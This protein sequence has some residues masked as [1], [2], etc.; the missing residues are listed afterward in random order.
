MAML[1]AASEA[2]RRFDRFPAVSALTIDHGLRAQA[3]EEARFVG[4][5]CRELGVPHRIVRLVTDAPKTGVQAWAREQRLRAFREAALAAPGSIVL[6]AH[7]ADD[8]VETNRM[9]LGRV[10]EGRGFE[11]FGIAPF[12]WLHGTWLYR[13]FI[14][15]PRHALRRFMIQHRLEWVEDPFNADDRFERARIRTWTPDYDALQDPLYE[16]QRTAVVRR[17]ALARAGAKALQTRVRR[18]GD[19]GFEI[20]WTPHTDRKDEALVMAIR[21]VCGHVG[22]H[23]NLPTALKIG[24]VLRRLQTGVRVTGAARCLFR[25]RADVLSI[26]REQRRTASIPARPDL[27]PWPTLVPAHD[28]PVA[29]ALYRVLKKSAIP[30]PPVAL[31]RNIASHV[32]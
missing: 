32:V 3:A 15:L 13:P 7:T 28:V 9:R 20:D 30:Q 6:A 1:H 25:L 2:K 26:E 5:V 12:A 10:G 23:V 31:N 18:L 8:S 22:S 11:A 29:D 16:E 19:L 27:H 24:S 21:T 4:C 17:V 14:G